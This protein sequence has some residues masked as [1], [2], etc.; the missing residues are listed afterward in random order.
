VS[1]LI[2]DINLKLIDIMALLY[3]WRGDNYWRDL[4]MGAGYH[5]NQGNPLLHRIEIGDSIWAFTRNHSGRYVL[6]AELIVKAKTENP[7]IFRYGRYRVWGDIQYSRYFQV[8]NQPSVEQII[9]S[10]PCKVNAPI[11]GQSFQGFSAVRFIT[12]EDNLILKAVA[13]HL[14]LEPRARILPEEKLE[15]ALLLEDPLAVEQLILQEQPGVAEQ[16]R[17]YLYTLAP[18]RNHRLVDKLQDLYSGQCQI[19][20]WDPRQHY[21]KSLC[22]G[23]HIHWLSRGGDDEVTNMVLVCPNHHSAIHK[24]DAPLDF[25]DMAF[26]F[27]IRR[28]YLQLNFHLK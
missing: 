20:L 11:L 17:Q 23:H 16:R 26:D 18:T 8:D 1:Q 5:L 22:Q 28:E 10:L 21:G 9:R 27:G 15:A 25:R 19:C 6:A 2:Y 13:K 7:P 24:I 4:N 3:Y 12:E 14:S